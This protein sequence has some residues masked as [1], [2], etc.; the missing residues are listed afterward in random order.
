M[1]DNE[2]EASKSATWIDTI[3]AGR[4]LVIGFVIALWIAT[5]V[6]LSRENSS[7][8]CLF[9]SGNCGGPVDPVPPPGLWIE[10]AAASGTVIVLT[11]LF[12]MSILPAVGIA[13]IAFAVV[14]FL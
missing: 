9:V 2:Q 1:S 8:I 5:I 13:A 7:I 11:T 6:F 3:P 14:S 10:I 12:G 4:I